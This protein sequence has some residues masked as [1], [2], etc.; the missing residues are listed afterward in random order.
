[1][2]F[3]PVLPAPRLPRASLH[4]RVIKHLPQFPRYQF[5][6]SRGSSTDLNAS[7]TDADLANARVVSPATSDQPTQNT[8]AAALRDSGSLKSVQT[9]TTELAPAT[10]PLAEVPKPVQEAAK[11][12]ANK[13]R[14][15]AIKPTLD[16]TGIRYEV[17]YRA[18]TGAQTTI[19]LDKD[20]SRVE[21]VD[22]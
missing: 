8:G 17:S 16:D 3:W 14:I 21:D 7:V 1:L 15:E 18:A 2:D 9:E 19:T 20:G 13:G 22:E 4:L 10:V 5:S 11:R 12:F 6:Q